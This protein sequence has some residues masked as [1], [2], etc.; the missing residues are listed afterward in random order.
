MHNSL[1]WLLNDIIG[2]ASEGNAIIVK[3]PTI[4]L[5]VR[6]VESFM[7]WIVVYKKKKFNV[8]SEIGERETLFRSIVSFISD[9][10]KA[11][12]DADDYRAHGR[13]SLVFEGN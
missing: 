11:S 5:S 1:K 2:Y 12:N 13:F 7:S 10:D 8:I 6:P 4:V 9:T 3:T